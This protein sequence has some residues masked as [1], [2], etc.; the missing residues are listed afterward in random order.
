MIN[1][2][3]VPETEEYNLE[4]TFHEVMYINKNLGIP[5]LTENN[6]LYIAPYWLEKGFRGVNRV[7]HIIETYLNSKNDFE[8]R[9]GNSFILPEEKRWDNMGSPRKFEYHNL[10]VFGLRELS[11]GILVPV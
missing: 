11:T 8:I 9:L 1:V 4:T 6:A 10:S 3:V 2:I 5:N 7:Y